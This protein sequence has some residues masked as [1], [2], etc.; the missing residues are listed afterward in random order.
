[1]NKRNAYKGL[2]K[3]AKSLL[4]MDEGYDV[5][6]KQNIEGLKVED[7]VAFA[8]SE[9]G[10]YILLGVDQNKD[11]SG[12]MS[13]LIVGCPV[14]DN[15]KL[16][17]L[18]KAN[19]CIPSIKIEIIVENSNRIPFYRIDIPSGTQKPYATKKGVYKIRGDGLN[20]P[21]LP[22]RLLDMFVAEKGDEFIQRFK[23]AT[24]DIESQVDQ[25]KRAMVKN[26]LDM[27]NTIENLAR[28]TE[29]NLNSIY[30]S[31]EQAGEVA[32]EAT[33]WGEEAVNAAEGNAFG[34]EQL[35]T[36]LSDLTILIEDLFTHFGR[37]TPFQ[38]VNERLRKEKV[39]EMAKELLKK[40]KGKKSLD[41][42][43]LK[44]IEDPG[45]KCWPFLTEDVVGELTE[46]AAKELE[47][48]IN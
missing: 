40:S 45:V 28:D 11:R 18:G 36:K 43:K 8:N 17:I 1:M 22:T 2:S 3:L 35:D 20:E 32:S 46:S 26:M 9:N 33:Y 42:I 15:S 24:S 16:R 30:S 31:A 23:S 39:K 6:F 4:Q 27:S 10:G 13:P 14:N 37:K 25:M 21:L 12:E 34:I 41:N 19:D 29:Q 7:L 48:D 5:D 47:E 38:K 44:L